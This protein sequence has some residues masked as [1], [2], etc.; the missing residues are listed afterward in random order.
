MSENSSGKKTDFGFRKVDVQEKKNLVSEVF[1]SVA[2]R[3]DLMNDVMSFGIHRAWKK[4]CI[5]LTSLR[6]HHYV[7]DLAAGTGDLAIRMAPLLGTTGNL[8]VTDI[9]ESML[10]IARQR[11]IAKGLVGN[12]HYLLVDAQQIPFPQDTF[13]CVTIGF[14]L[15]NVTDKEAALHSIHRVLKP[16]GKLIILEFS[17]PNVPLLSSLYDAYSFNVLPL[18]GKIFA[19]DEASYR[20]LAESIR[21]HPN[22]DTLLHM[23]E[24]AG[25]EQCTYHNLTGGIVAIHRGYKF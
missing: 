21:M 8:F 12:I 14:G 11:M 9:N 13:D 1:H 18:L 19:K 2:N 17:H 25:F 23:M 6:S 4:F 16:G 7:L 15:R 20:Y 22:Q 24:T 5:E 3:Y 10:T